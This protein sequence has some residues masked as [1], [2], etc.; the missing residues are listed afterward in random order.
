VV[1]DAWPDRVFTGHVRRVSPEA[2]FTPRTIQ[3]RSD[4]DRLVYAVE[5]ALDN[6]DGALRV[7]MPV[8]VRL[9]PT[10]AGGTGS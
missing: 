10:N 1:A 9:V 6:P 8:E 3:T 4:R 2:E 7:G 5:A